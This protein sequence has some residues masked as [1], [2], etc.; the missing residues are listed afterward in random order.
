VVIRGI[1]TTA[2]FYV[3]GVRDDAQIFRDLYNLER[4]EVL[5]GPAGMIFGRGGAGG[6]VNR[7]TKRPIFG[8]IAEASVTVGSYD[9]LR[10]T[11]DVGNKL[12]DSTAFRF[13]A[14]AERADSFRDGVDLGRYAVNPTI[15]FALS[16]Q[17]ALTLDYEHLHDDRTA[18][19]GIPSR[20][21]A[22]F[23]TGRSTFF[24]NAGQSDAR[25]TVDA[26]AAVLDHDFGGGTQFKNSLR[27]ARYDKFYQNV[28]AGSA[29]SA[30]GTL[31]LSAYNNANQR[32]NIFNQSDLTT[33][34]T[35]AGLQHTLLTGIELGH[36]NSSNQRNTGFFGAATAVTV[37]GDNP[38]AVATDFR[39]AGTDA[40]NTVQSD[41]AAVYVQDQ[42]ALS[43]QWKLLA[44]LR[45]D[46][47]KVDFDDRRTT[48]PA[49]DLSRTDNAFSPRAGLIWTP[50]PA[51]S[52]YVSYSY[53]FLPSGEQLS[54]AATTADLAPEKA[55]NYEIGAR[56]DLLPKLTFSAA[57]FRL[58][59]DDVRVADP[60]NP[61]FFVNTGQ[62]RTEGVELGLQG[63][64][65]RWWHVFGG[66]ARLDGRIT[67]PI[68]SGTA[69]TAASVVP[70]GNK[71]GLVPDDTFSVWNKFALGGGWD[72]GLGV[73]HQ[74]SSYTSFNNTVTLPGF[75]RV[76]GALY[77]TFAG[78]RTRI[79]LNVENLFDKKYFP[80]VDGDNN[81]SPGAPISARVTL[82][83]AF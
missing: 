26:F 14:M 80:T 57:V 48:T 15:T 65:T 61:G 45:Y 39:Q 77:Y 6:V 44:G 73:I 31:T 59:R 20:N 22:P 18:D 42:I 35:T 36:Q 11:I 70:A 13:N 79:A 52:Y 28:F 33:K 40:N 68:T 62:Q 72:A 41:T 12:N 4:V 64:V 21:G 2:D 38:F 10:T 75:T 3:N 50:T 76:D 56:W 19:R 17:T 58:D 71:I 9:Q 55:K 30:A 66:Y 16:G 69:A 29:V 83:T 5:K 81:I 34:F 53:A 7:V 54:L 63:E 60:L 78:G 8:R 25:S 23:D 67:K 74:S 37:A 43:P 46:R 47:F 82:S 27:I 1:S 51:S 24:G 49:V 32:T